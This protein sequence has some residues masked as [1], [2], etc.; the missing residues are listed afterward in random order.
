EEGPRARRTYVGVEV[1][2][3][4]ETRRNVAAALLPRG[5]VHVRLRAE[6]DAV[7][8]ARLGE[9]LVTQRSAVLL[10]ALESHIVVVEGQIEGEEAIRSLE[11]RQGGLGDLRT[12]TVP[13]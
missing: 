7:V 11:H 3:H 8:S 13:G 1:Q 6:N 2:A 9:R 5:I 4:P 12:D 10:Q